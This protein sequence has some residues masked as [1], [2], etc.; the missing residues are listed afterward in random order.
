MKV[1]REFAIKL[2]DRATDRH[3]P[4][5][6]RLCERYELF[7]GVRELPTIQDV[8]EALGVTREELSRVRAQEEAKEKADV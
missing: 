6:E 3:D 1:T 7:E 4:F 5:W 8:F 2:F